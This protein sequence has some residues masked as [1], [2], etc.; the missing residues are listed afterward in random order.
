MGIFIDLIFNVLAPLLF[1]IALY[2]TGFREKT[3]RATL[4]AIFKKLTPGVLVIGQSRLPRNTRTARYQRKKQRR[5]IFVANDALIK[6][7]NLDK[8]NKG[9]NSFELGEEIK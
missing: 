9:H 2:F 4:E 5:E 3:H 8:D 7:I 1:F 6:I